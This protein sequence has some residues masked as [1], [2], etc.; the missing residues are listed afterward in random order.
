MQIILD[1]VK[2]DDGYATIK[3]FLTNVQEDKNY[4]NAYS[5][6]ILQ[7]FWQLRTI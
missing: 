6:V 7:M 2:A 3:F 4:R 1:S 5:Q